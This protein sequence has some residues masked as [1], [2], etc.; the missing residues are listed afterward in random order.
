MAGVIFHKQRGDE[1][2]RV[3]IE[4]RMLIG[5]YDVPAMLLNASSRG[6]LAALADPPMRG[7]RVKLMVGDAVLVG[8]VRW[9]GVDCCG[10]ALRDPISVSDL[11]GGYAVPASFI[12]EPQALRGFGG[13]LRT[14][15]RD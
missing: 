10:I 2:T 12:P 6:V 5:D 11:L 1:R 4:A 8:Q 13:M 9:H 14:L 15:L 7:T 3:A